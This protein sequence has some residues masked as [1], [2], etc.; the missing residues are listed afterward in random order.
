MKSNIQAVMERGEK[1]EQLELTS[2]EYVC[3]RARTCVC[4]WVGG[5]VHVFMCV[6][7]VCMRLCE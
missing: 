6:V 3:V 5:W 1:V 7:C 4:V 2:G